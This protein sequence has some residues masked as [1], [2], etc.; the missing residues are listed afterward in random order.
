MSKKYNIPI[1]F[2]TNSVIN[3]TSIKSTINIKKYI[4]CNIVNNTS[5]YYFIKL[6]SIHYRGIMK[7]NNLI[8]KNNSLTINIENDVNNFNN[9]NTDINESIRNN[10]DIIGEAIEN[11]EKILEKTKV[12]KNIILLAVKNNVL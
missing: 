11:S 5:D 3:I 12:L 8:H 2:I 6:P 1:I 10:E 7:I 4:I 9:I